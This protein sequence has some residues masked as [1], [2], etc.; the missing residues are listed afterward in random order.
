MSYKINGVDL[1]PAAQT[2]NSTEVDAVNGPIPQFC[3]IH[4]LTDV[5]FILDY[6]IIAHYWVNNP[7]DGTNKNNPGN[8]ILYNRWQEQ[9]TID[10]TMLSTRTRRGSF[11]I[12][13]DNTA[14]I[15]PDLLRT[16]MAVI[17]VPYNFVRQQSQYEI[18]ADGLSL[19]YAIMDREVFKMPP[20]P[21]FKAD[22]YFEELG[23]GNLAAYREGHVHVKLWG[24]PY[25]S[26]NDLYNTAWT[27]AAEKM[28]CN[29]GAPIAM[30]ATAH[31]SVPAEKLLKIPL[32][33][34]IRSKV[35]M[36]DNIVE[37]EAVAML[38]F[39]TFRF[40]GAAIA[41]GN[42]PVANT[43]TP[44]SDNQPVVPPEYL[45]RG[46]A[47]LLLQAAAYWDPNALNATQLQPGK[48]TT[49]NN[50]NTSFTPAFT[51]P[52]PREVLP[53]T[54]PGTSK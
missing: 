26:Q 22:G 42:S 41:H 11:R 19:N 33:T 38:N 3:N 36:Y 24:A 1:I 17:S 39:T 8:P 44:G 53:G 48:D 15:T 20:S 49:I 50:A 9:V 23:T 54:V 14:G 12:R 7:G 5:T 40:A 37:I 30:L 6:G 27:V 45:D 18:T 43:F 25:I 10:E 2:G 21:A 51:G 35:W 4:Q 52:T 13:S 32:Y 29:L 34:N 46:S 31:G 47:Q 16:Q 28:A